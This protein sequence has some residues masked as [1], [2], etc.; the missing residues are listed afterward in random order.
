MKICGN[1]DT[2][3]RIPSLGIGW[4]WLVSIKLW[5]HYP[6]RIRTRDWVTNIK[7]KSCYKK[8]NS[9]FL[10]GLESRWSNTLLT[11]PCKHLSL[12]I[13]LKGFLKEKETANPCK[14]VERRLEVNPE[15]AHLLLIPWIV[16]YK[17][18][19]PTMNETTFQHL[20]LCCTQLA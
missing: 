6:R 9:L 13:L 10:P 11:C 3:P 18:L 12:H 16:A 20:R 1:R 19:E 15:L 17:S 2:S 5:P 7:Y 8:N 4:K 14:D